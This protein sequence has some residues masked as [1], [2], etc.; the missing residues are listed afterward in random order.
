MWGVDV[1]AED[2]D[3]DKHEAEICGAPNRKFDVVYDGMC[4]QYC[5]AGKILAVSGG[6]DG[7]GFDMIAIDESELNVDRDALAA[8][9]SAQFGKTFTASDFSLL[10]FSHFS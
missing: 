1:G 9:V 6:Y 8:V 3:C 4:G 10:L 2:I 5:I 7:D